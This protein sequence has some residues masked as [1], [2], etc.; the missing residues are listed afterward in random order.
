[1]K[2]LIA[3]WI[4]EFMILGFIA[5]TMFCA[6][7]SLG[8]LYDERKTKT[9]RVFVTLIGIFVFAFLLYLVYVFTT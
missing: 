3:L 6:I 2:E 7:L 5:T 8:K 1:M 9:G 4:A